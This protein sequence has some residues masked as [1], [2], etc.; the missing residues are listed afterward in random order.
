MAGSSRVKITDRDSGH[1]G[2]V[3]RVIDG[4]LL[5]SSAGGGGG[6]GDV[7]IIEVG[8]VPV[9][10]A[11]VPIN[12]AGGSVT[13]D[14]VFFPAVQSVDDAGG[15]LTVDGVFF[16]ATQP[17]SGSVGILGQPIGVDDNGGSLTVDGVFFPASQ[18]VDQATHDLLNLNANIQVGDADASI[19]NPVPVVLVDNKIPITASTNG[20]PVAIAAIA[21]PGTNLHT[22]IA[23]NRDIVTL[24]ATN[25]TAVDRRLTLEM[26]GV[27]VADQL[28][29]FVPALETVT[30]LDEA[31]IQAG[32][33]IA[34]FLDAVA[35]S[36]NAF[37][38][39]RREL[40]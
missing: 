24:W 25:T 1:G 7:N 15:S 31:P 21:T 19:T 3:A 32:L 20:R 2:S 16:P 11:S 8:G 33:S 12:D 17:I 39:F 9:G 23:L 30:I 4:R 28:H 36:V 5:V 29:F 35:S 6:G 40:I 22:S 18:T 10:G 38:Y 37:G 26:G 34:A 14:G 27:G 13:V